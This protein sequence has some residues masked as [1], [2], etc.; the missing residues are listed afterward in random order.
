M[1]IVKKLKVSLHKTV[2]FRYMY[3]LSV[4]INKRPVFIIAELLYQFVY[5]PFFFRRKK[6][7]E[8]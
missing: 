6:E 7:K 8:T 1:K 5:L 3:I 2:F 4:H